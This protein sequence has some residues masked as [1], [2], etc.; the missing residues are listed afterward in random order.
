LGGVACF[1]PKSA[2]KTKI[3]GDLG[4]LN[5]VKCG[6]FPS[7]PIKIQVLFSKNLVK[8]QVFHGV[9]VQNPGKCRFFRV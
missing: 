3:F 1:D 4:L 9:G 8:M 6:V 5:T 2:G 7:K